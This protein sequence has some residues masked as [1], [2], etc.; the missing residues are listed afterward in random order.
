MEAS[1]ASRSARLA[2]SARSLPLV[3]ASAVTGGVI[4]LSAPLLPD[5]GLRL[6][7][8]GVAAVAFA[9]LA[10]GWLAGAVAVL[11]VVAP[12]HAL[13][14]LAPE[15]LRLAKQAM[16]LTILAA[17][18]TRHATGR[19]AS[20]SRNPMLP[21]MVSYGGLLLVSAL[22]S[23]EVPTGLVTAAGELGILAMFLCLSD[24]V[25][26]PAD[27]RVLLFTTLAAAAAWAIL[28]VVATMNHVG[29]ILI[30]PVSLLGLTLP[31]GLAF[32]IAPHSR[33]RAFWLAVVVATAAVII[34][35]NHRGTALAV[36][37]GAALVVLARWGWRAMVPLAGLLGTT[38]ILVAG[39][40][41]D[42]FR[43]GSGLT[44]RPGLWVAA[45]GIFADHP[46]FGAGP[47]SFPSLYRAYQPSVMEEPL[48]SR[49]TET[50][51]HAHNIYLNALAELGIL[52][53][54][55]I[56][57]LLG[58]ILTLAF[59]AWRAHARG[60]QQPLAVGVFATLAAAGLQEL[61]E[62]GTIF[63]NGSAN[64]FFW[65]MAALAV[66]LWRDIHGQ[67]APTVG[68]PDVLIPRP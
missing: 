64:L 60:Q 5:D 43:P 22:M 68:K 54:F 13:P 63:R 35:S 45:V 36:G 2:F 56:A 28:A 14:G 33:P 32:L 44:G 37:L 40:G 52:G 53:P 23:A 39:P 11:I 55:A 67:S 20:Q 42:Y 59:W 26:R 9:V 58:A 18:V 21:F 46:W 1:P 17:W 47:G 10:F 24:L 31:V 51:P 7:A 66:G 12:L 38:A 49:I 19:F 4:A 16:A 65:M 34:V 48:A 8:L 29:G 62:S 3:G 15:P 27:R 61:T 41:A 25:G 50:V 30:Q 6:M 57:L